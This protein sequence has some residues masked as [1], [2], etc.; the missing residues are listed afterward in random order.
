MISAILRPF[1]IYTHNETFTDLQISNLLTPGEADKSARKNA[2]Y[3]AR[4]NSMAY[5]KG[6][7]G[8]Q[9][10][11]R[12]KYS[13]DF[14]RNLGYAPSSNA[15]S[16]VLIEANIKTY[17]QNLYGY[18]NVSILEYVDKYMTLA[19][20]TAHAVREN[21]GY[22]FD[23]EKTTISGSVYTLYNSSAGVTEDTVILDYL[24]DP[25]E[26][27]E[28]N[29]TANYLYDPLTNYV[30]IGG[31]LYT[32]DI[33]SSVING[34]YTTVA[35]HNDGVLPDQNIITNPVYLQ[36][37][38]VNSLY[39]SEVTFV[40]YNVLSGEVSTATRYW[41]AAADT[42]SELYDI[43]ITEVTAIVPLKE[44]N[45]MVD[46]EARKL[47]RMLKRLNLSGE[48]LRS[49]ITNP[50][51]D[52]AYL[53]TGIDPQYNDSIT[54]KT[55]FK[56]FD[57]LS[58][59]TLV[60]GVNTNVSISISNLNL[61]YVYG[62]KITNKTGSIGAVGTC[63]RTNWTNTGMVLRLQQ[64]STEYQEMV[65]SNFKQTYTV[66]GSGF[67]ADLKSTGG[68]CRIIIPLNI[69]NS[70]KYREWEFIYERALCLMAYAT[71][72]VEVQWYETGAFGTLLKIVAAVIT[73]ITL[74]AG[75]GIG[76]ALVT[77]AATIAFYIGVTLTLTA[78]IIMVVVQYVLLNL[79]IAELAAFLGD[80]IGGE[81]GRILAQ[82]V[83]AY[84][85]FEL[86]LVQVDFGSANTWIMMANQG[87]GTVQEYINHKT[88]NIM[89]EMESF[90]K[91]M[92]DKLDY[93]YEKLD[94]MKNDVGGMFD[95]TE[96][97]TPP[98][99]FGDIESY[100]NKILNVDVDM[101]S[102]YGS[103]IDYNIAVRSNVV[104]GLG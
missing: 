45:V 14:M 66:S 6:Y 26:A 32:V 50:D 72:T 13:A 35:T 37:T 94:E 57:A 63:T 77:M 1:G 54:N 60:N 99:M 39:A 74:G 11:Y 65:I 96:A 33:P 41:I 5:F 56:T 92:D 30:T 29:L 101:L 97:G 79:V 87:L 98:Q 69:Y 10:D 76:A 27:I 88:T 71:E 51:I 67:D 82:A 80:A 9:R 46:L 49:S 24:L 42:I 64:N 58:P 15:R 81:F 89:N 75:S 104:S 44:N 23:T 55:L 2:K 68:Y 93:L 25:Y 103:Q 59:V 91:E 70:L 43:A 22:D 73:I 61:K 34:V 8:F 90:M 3:R 40:R 78:L 47:E 28:D 38:V 83:I 17:I 20:K 21:P 102:D 36:D 12:R 52:G 95:M 18:A 16:Y 86:G 84:V 62:V 7:R 19:D 48:Q 4:G 53:M 31:E 85:G 100:V